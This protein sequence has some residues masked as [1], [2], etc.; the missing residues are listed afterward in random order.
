M[1]VAFITGRSSSEI[2]SFAEL[3]KLFV[4]NFANSDGIGD[5]AE[6]LYV[7]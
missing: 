2:D 1:N 3:T 5:I 7:V 4:G 6:R